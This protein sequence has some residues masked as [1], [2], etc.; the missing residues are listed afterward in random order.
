MQY[1]VYYESTSDVTIDFY[2][3]ISLMSAP[4][5]VKITAGET[6]ALDYV[7]YGSSIAQKLIDANSENALA[8]AALVYIQAAEQM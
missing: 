6:T 2:L 5:S 4:I 3:P 1:L 8:K 7:D